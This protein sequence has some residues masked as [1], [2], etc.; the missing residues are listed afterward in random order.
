MNLNGFSAALPLTSGTLIQTTMDREPIC[1]P[2]EMVESYI[3]ESSP[4]ETAGAIL[5]ER[6]TADAAMSDRVVAGIEQRCL[7]LT[8]PEPDPLR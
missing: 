1:I 4:I 7:R 5:L 3:R 6:I 8:S 2:L